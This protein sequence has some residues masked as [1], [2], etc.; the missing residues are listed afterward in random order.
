MKIELKNTNK[1]EAFQLS[2]RDEERALA[3]GAEL[4][5]HESLFTFDRK[6]ANQLPQAKLTE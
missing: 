3:V 2:K 1:P 5:H 6:L 4:S